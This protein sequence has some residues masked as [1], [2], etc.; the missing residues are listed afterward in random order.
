[1]K[2]FI[3]KTKKILQKW[4]NQTKLLNGRAL[5]ILKYNNSTTK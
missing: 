4:N 5:N 2:N 3:W 1:M